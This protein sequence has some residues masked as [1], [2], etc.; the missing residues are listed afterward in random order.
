MMSRRVE[1]AIDSL[2]NLTEEQK[3]ERLS[4]L[5]AQVAERADSD[6]PILMMARA[7]K[8]ELGDRLPAAIARTLYRP[9]AR[10]LYSRWKDEEWRKL[11]S[12]QASL[13]GH[14]GRLLPTS[15]LVDAIVALAR[16]ERDV[17][18]VQAIVNY[19]FD[20]LL[21]E[22]L[23]E[24]HVKC[25]TVLSG[26]D[27]IPQGTLPCYHVH[28]LVSSRDVATRK[29]ARVQGNF[30]FSED[31]YHAEYS[32]PYRWSNMTQM[33]L[34]GRYTGLFVGLSLEDP[35]IRRLIDVTHRQYPE[36]LNYA[37]LPRKQRLDQRRDNNDA[38]MKNLFEEVE[39]NSFDRIGVRVIW[40][41]S[42]N[43]IPNL[44]KRICGADS[45]G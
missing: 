16:S 32:D 13:L 30:V 11:R 29:A 12:E 35:N 41:D 4:R 43:Q 25:R 36:N 37:V 6:K 17:Q 19:N 26:R 39:S 44:L 1:T 27:V 3:W 8:D 2:K 42:F 10:A 40:V 22:K 9:V 15:A 34:L 33:S 23:R 45:A 21:D 31:E 38:V 5:Q 14:R 20:D 7:V 24:Q 28:G 18:G